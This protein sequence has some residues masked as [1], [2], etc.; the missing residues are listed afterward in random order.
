[1]DNAERPCVHK[2]SSETLPTARERLTY[3][4]NPIYQHK[5]MIG[6]TDPKIGP[7]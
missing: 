7:R 2:H 1:M 4:T 3:I 5:K 6:E